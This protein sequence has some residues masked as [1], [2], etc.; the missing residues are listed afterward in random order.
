MDAS[1]APYPLVVFSHGFSSN[2]VWYSTIIEHLASHGFIVFAP[3]HVE[4]FDPEWSEIWSAS[5]DRPQDI[6]QTLDY[7]EQMTA[8]DGELAGLIDME[9]VAVAGH[10]YGG[11]TDLAMAGAQYDLEA[12]NA[13]C[14]ELPADD[15]NMFLCAP[16]VPKEADM[17]AHA[18]LDPMPEGLWPSFGDPRVKA[19]LPMAGDSYLFDQAGLAK[20][21]VPMMAIGGTADTGTPYDWGSK[22][23]Y[24]YAS[25]AKKALVAL[26]GAEHTIR[27]PATTCPGLP[28][29]RSICGS[30]S[31]QSGTR[32]GDR[33]DQPLCDRLPAGRAEGR[34]RSSSS[35]GAGECGVPGHQYEATGYD[36]RLPLRWTRPPLPR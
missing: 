24:D 1:A 32:R 9:N 11:Y 13:R 31:T 22:P 6:K 17:A 23:S 35:P 19:I 26:E 27:P 36:R 5:I 4:H 16:V 25:S 8:P 3:E 29:P 28:K 30:V 2:A 14:A 12:F 10:S 21:T 34:P 33:S 20:I 18:G 7:A 15:P